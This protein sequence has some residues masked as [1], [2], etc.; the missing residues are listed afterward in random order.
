M[1]PPTV[2]ELRDIAN[3]LHGSAGFHDHQAKHS[4]LTVDERQTEIRL[5]RRAKLT[6]LALERWA[7]DIDRKRPGA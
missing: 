1:K 3:D 4:N 7:H 5:E 2:S 6:A